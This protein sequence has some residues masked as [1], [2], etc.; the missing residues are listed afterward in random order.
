AQPNAVAAAAVAAPAQSAVGAAAVAAGGG[1][2]PQ[3]KAGLIGK[4]AQG[5]SH[6]SPGGRGEASPPSREAAGCGRRVPL[7]ALPREASAEQA[8]HHA[9]AVTK[10]KQQEVLP[11]ARGEKG[12]LYR[13]RLFPFTPKAAQAACTALRKKGMECTVIRPATH[14][15]SR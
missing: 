11:P 15:A 10:G 5:G 12:A 6:P 7:G 4:I 2:A 13:A 3:D 9:V 14:L 1:D 8:I